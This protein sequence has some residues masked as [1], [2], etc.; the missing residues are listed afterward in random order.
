MKTLWTPWRME[1]VLDQAARSP[2]CCLFALPGDK[3]FAGEHL[4]LPD[5][6][7]LLKAE[8]DHE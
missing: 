2:G 8:N 3:P 5:F 1:H 7:E 4:L 6:Q